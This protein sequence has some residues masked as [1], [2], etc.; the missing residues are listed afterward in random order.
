MRKNL[1][2]FCVLALSLLWVGAAFAQLNVSAYFKLDTDLAT[3]GYQETTPKVTGI[4]ATKNVGFAIYSQALEN[5]KAFTV[6]FEWNS[7]KATLR[8][9]SGVKPYNDEITVNGATI[10]PPDEGNILGTSVNSLVVTDL[11]GSYTV[12]TFQM[13]EVPAA[14][15]PVGLIYFAVFRTT[16]TFTTTDGFYIKVS[17]TVAGEAV[18]KN[19]E[20]SLGYRYFYVNS[21]AVKSSTWG[22]VKNQFKDF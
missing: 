21:V 18:P 10:T 12:S 7:A 14:T 13:G 9:S 4:G 5:A 22:D 19:I 6:S 20:T 3:Q 2:I 17:V 16:D 1:T 15:D 11:P 8:P